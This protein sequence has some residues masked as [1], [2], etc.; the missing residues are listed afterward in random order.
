MRLISFAPKR[1]TLMLAAAAAAAAAFG[2]PAEASTK[3]LGIGV[4]GEERFS[5]RKIK[6]QLA[7]LNNS[8]C[9]D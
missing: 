4:V 1:A 9:I 8:E 6:R 2:R 7:A 5:A 3:C